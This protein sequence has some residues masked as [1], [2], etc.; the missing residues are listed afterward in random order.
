MENIWAGNEKKC[1]LNIAPDERTC[2]AKKLNDMVIISLLNPNKI[3]I[4]LQKNE[5]MQDFAHEISEFSIVK[6]NKINR[7]IACEKRQSNKLEYIKINSAD[8]TTN[9]NFQLYFLY[10]QFI[11]SQ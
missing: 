5:H 2:F 3:Q 10:L 6:K 7:F 11:I 8:I 1:R 4:A 9:G